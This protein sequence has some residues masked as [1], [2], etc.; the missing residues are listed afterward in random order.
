M[1]SAA[2]VFLSCFLGV[3]VA[4]GLIACSPSEPPPPITPGSAEMLTS[5]AAP[6]AARAEIAAITEV[7]ITG[8]VRF[9][10]SGDFVRIEA[11]IRGL[12]DGLYGFHIHSGTDC[13]ERGGHYDPTGM[14]HGS[15]DEPVVL[16]HVGDL[17]NL[18][19][20]DGIAHFV[21]IDPVVALDGE[22]SVI[23]RIAVVHNGQDQLLP[24]PAGDSGMQIGCGVIR[25][26]QGG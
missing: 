4:V 3:G 25:V 12:D 5:A 11:E 8:E 2:R 26:G 18:V 16:R 22:H 23:G 6:L 13:D 17:G 21:R 20:R 14:P 24:Q 1:S 7:G 19:S 15:P 10:E 9:S